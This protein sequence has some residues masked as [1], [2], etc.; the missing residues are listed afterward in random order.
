MNRVS[1]RVISSRFIYPRSQEKLC[2]GKYS[3]VAFVLLELGP[4]CRRCTDSKKLNAKLI[5]LY[6]TVKPISTL[7]SRGA[8]SSSNSNILNRVNY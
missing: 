7:V 8:I 6:N 5:I 4:R 2:F 3:G 1:N